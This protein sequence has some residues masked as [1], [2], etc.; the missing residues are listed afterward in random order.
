MNELSTA[1]PLPL[2]FG[3]Q[4]KK[5]RKIKCLCWSKL[6][7]FWDKEGFSPMSTE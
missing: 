4:F 2:F 7:T 3:G 1:L 6:L 5:I